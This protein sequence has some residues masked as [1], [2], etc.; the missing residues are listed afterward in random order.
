MAAFYCFRNANFKIPFFLEP[1]GN[2]F[3]S[4][5]GLSNAYLKS[6]QVFEIYILESP[7]IASL[8]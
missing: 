4:V 5:N 3:E 8:F 1:Q 2:N 7:E 6:F